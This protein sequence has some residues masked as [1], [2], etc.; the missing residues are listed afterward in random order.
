M[1]LKVNAFTDSQYNDQLKGGV[2]FVKVHIEQHERGLWFRK[3]DFVAL[4]TPG[5]HFKLRWLLR[6]LRHKVEIIDTLRTRFEHPLLDVL[7]TR[8]E[9][10]DQLHIADP[11]DGHRALIW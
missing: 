8:S 10:R 4:L 11:A 6:P 5:T 1:P 7:I 9:L 2:M 3:G